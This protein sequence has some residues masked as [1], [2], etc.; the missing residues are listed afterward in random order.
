MIPVYVHE[1]VK[2]SEGTSGQSRVLRFLADPP[3]GCV[4]SSAVPEE[5]TWGRHHV[6]EVT[7][8]NAKCE[9][10]VDTKMSSGV[11]ERTY[12]IVCSWM[13][14]KSVCGCAAHWRKWSC[15]GLCLLGKS[16]R[17]STWS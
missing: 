4:R 12:C 13:A 6:L 15:C 7:E 8:D 9:L 14:A 3:E 10:S 1:P 2:N 16:K 11:L 5:G 17:R